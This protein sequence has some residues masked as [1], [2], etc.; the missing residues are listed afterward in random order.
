MLMIP[1]VN[2]IEYNQVE[3]N[4]KEKITS[5]YMSEVVEK[6]KEALNYL[7]NNPD[8]LCLCCGEN[9]LKSPNCK[10]FSKYLL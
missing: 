3:N 9:S 4:N 8:D 7:E 5:T 2:A 1:S 6:L 10:T